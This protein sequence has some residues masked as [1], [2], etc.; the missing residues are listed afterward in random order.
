MAHNTSKTGFPPIPLTAGMK[1]RLEARA[2]TTNAAVS[3]ASASR[4]SIWG[5]QV[6][7]TLDPDV[8]PHY[9]PDDDGSGASY[10]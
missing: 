5:Y 1:I 4:W 7:D 6:T 8:I 10:A 2:T 9:S 3:G